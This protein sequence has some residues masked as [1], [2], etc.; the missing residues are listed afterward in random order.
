MLDFLR[1]RKRSWVVTFLLGLVVVVFV[2]FY[3]GRGMKEPGLEKIASINGEVITQ[4]EFGIYYQRLIDRYRELFKRALTPE[5]IKSLNLK[6]A[7][8]EELIQRH[9]LLQETQR[10]KLEVTDEEL[11]DAIARIP[12][13]QV[14]GRFSKNRYLQL[15]RAS[16]LTPG[17]FEAERREQRAIQKLYDMIQD[18]VYVTENEAREQYRVEQE[19][20][21]FAF[22]RLSASDFISRAEVTVEESKNYYDRNRETLK[23]PLRVQVDYLVYPIG[24]SSSKVQVGE[25]EI[26]EFYKLHRDTRFRQPRAIRLR[27]ILFRVPS[28]AD[29]KQKEKLR[30]KAEA[31]A[32]ESRSGKDFAELAKKYSE[33]P[34]AAQGG[35]VGWVTQGQM[36]PS[37]DQ[38]AFAL[39]KGEVSGVVESP[40]GYHI[41]KVEELREEKIKGIKEAT[42]EIT[43]LLAAERGKAEAGRAV[44]A[45]REKAASGA[46]LSALAKQRGIPYRVSPFFGRGD[47]VP[48]VE[49]L[50]EFSKAALSL[51]V[52]EV[53]PAIQGANAYYLLRVKQ[54]K[55]P[56]VPALE[57]VRPEIEKRIKETKASELARQK[58]QALLDQLKK[59]KDIHKLAQEPGLRLEET[60]WFSRSDAAIPRIGT[61]QEVKPGGIAISARQPVA[62]RLYTQ[63]N[64]VYL[65]AFKERQE[66]DLEQFE[67]EK[68]RL[69][70]QALAQKKQQAMKKLIEHLKA[71]AR[72]DVQSNF[73][74]ES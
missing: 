11:T 51:G 15:L 4:R 26:E 49:P 24:P 64:S 31:V 69:L 62:D 5:A 38:A 29:A 47:V 46:D 28:G 12:E 25:K 61:L 27:N 39:K 6:G 3:G 37:L 58:A 45:D 21:N 17:Q 68:G 67:R 23:E 7:V 1:K 43:R 19:R 14:N 33:D 60:G 56:T 52:N 42:P 44:D 22:I 20:V 18:S 36:I 30:P 13:F 73:F 63:K 70:E 72:V 66:A 54:R 53:S 32:Q 71:K 59:E 16:R 9:L 74:D 48:E 8:V 55:E 35:E 41:L 34:S 2:L 10:L 50:E 40:L 57:A 65:F